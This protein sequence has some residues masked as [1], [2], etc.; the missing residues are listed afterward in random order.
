MLGVLLLSLVYF[1]L[2]IHQD[3]RS[4]ACLCLTVGLTTFVCTLQDPS[5]LH[6]NAPASP[7]LVSHILFPLPPPPMY[8][9]AHQRPRI[10]SS[11]LNGATSP[12]NSSHQLASTLAI[13]SYRCV[14]HFVTGT[15]A[16]VDYEAITTVCTRIKYV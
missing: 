2:N 5:L 14:Q 9:I 12:T 15:I 10:C 3:P 1:I 6:T 13:V 16:I 4:S 11:S 8:S 7:H